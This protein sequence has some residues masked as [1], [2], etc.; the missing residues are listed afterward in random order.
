MRVGPESTAIFCGPFL[1][2]LRTCRA[3]SGTP[4]TARMTR[5]TTA[6]TSDARLFRIVS[7]G[8]RHAPS[9]LAT[10]IFDPKN[11]TPRVDALI[12]LMISRL[13]SYPPGLDEPAYIP[14]RFREGRTALPASI[15]TDCVSESGVEVGVKTVR[16]VHARSATSPTE[17]AGQRI[18]TSRRRWFPL[19][20]HDNLCTAAENITRLLVVDDNVDVRFAMYECLSAE[21]FDVAVAENGL[22]GLALAR[23]VEPHAILLDIGMPALDGFSTARAM[24]GI[25]AF[26]TTPMIAVTGFYDK[27]HFDD[28]KASGFDFYFQKPVEIDALLDLLRGRRPE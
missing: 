22:R 4:L 26:A 20:Q 7:L 18:H 13:H 16:G 10:D 23:M 15:G 5:L 2:C 6:G 24:R 19:G 25:P 27:P 17:D 12:V 1:D 9:V 3:L 11:E 28:A 8:E 21:G 14:R